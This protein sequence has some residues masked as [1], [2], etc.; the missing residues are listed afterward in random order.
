MIDMYTNISITHEVYS[1][2]T[3]GGSFAI[4]VPISARVEEERQVIRLADG[5]EAA[6]SILVVSKTEI[7]EGDRLTI[8]G[9]KAIVLQVH[10]VRRL[11]GTIV[12]YEALC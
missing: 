10:R 8:D 12:W 1:D 9:S 5:R 4:G 11:D 7:S 2:S 6:S 3:Y